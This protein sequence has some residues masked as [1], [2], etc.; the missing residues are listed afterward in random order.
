MTNCDKLQEI[1]QNCVNYCV[2]MTQEWTRQVRV[3]FVRHRRHLVNVKTT[4]LSLMTATI[5][6]RTTEHN[7][8]AQ[9]LVSALEIQRTIGPLIRVESVG[10]ARERLSR[11]CYVTETSF[12]LFF[13]YILEHC[14]LHTRIVNCNFL[15]MFFGYKAD[16]KA[17]L[18]GIG[19]RI[20][21][22]N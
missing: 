14:S 15:R 19:S 17:Q 21:K 5:T 9:F 6:C 4:P 2:S 16:F 7:V 12:A 11:S 13:S 18:H 3:G 10:N 20:V 22:C 1:L 8:R